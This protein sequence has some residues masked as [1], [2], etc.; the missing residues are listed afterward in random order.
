MSV[1]EIMV[2][3]WLV[4]TPGERCGDFPVPISVTDF[5]FSSLNVGAIQDKTWRLHASFIISTA[6]SK[7]MAPNLYLLPE[8]SDLKSQDMQ[9]FLHSPW[10]MDCFYRILHIH[11]FPRLKTHTRTQSRQNWSQVD[12]TELSLILFGIATGKLLKTPIASNFSWQCP[13]MYIREEFME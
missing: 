1:G 12:H 6:P 11:L 8:H 3:R 2:T 9:Y 10:F 7:G 4:C 13:E 5:D